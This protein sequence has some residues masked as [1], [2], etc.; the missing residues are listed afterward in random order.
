MRAALPRRPSAKA[1][2]RYPKAPHVHYA[3]GVFFLTEDSERALADFRREL[4]ISPSHVPARLQIA[5]EYLKRG[6]AALA[7]PLALS[8]TIAVGTAALAIATTGLA[9]L[10]IAERLARRCV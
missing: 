6:E 2:A 9:T 3:R 4:E 7:L 10:T 1:V 8:G 5:F